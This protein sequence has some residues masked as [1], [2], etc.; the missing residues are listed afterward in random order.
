MSWANMFNGGGG[1]GGAGVLEAA[2]TA[3]MEAALWALTGFSDLGDGFYDPFVSG[4][5]V[6]LTN[7]TQSVT[8]GTN[9][10]PTMTSNTSPSGVC[11]ASSTYDASFPAW[12][13]ADKVNSGTDGWGSNAVP[14]EASPQWWQYEF[15]SATR[16]VSFGMQN[17]VNFPNSPA[18]FAIYATNAA[19]PGTNYTASEWVK[20]LDTTTNTN[21]TGGAVLGPWPAIATGDFTKYRKVITARNSTNTNVAIGEVLFYPTASSKITPTTSGGGS[22]NTDVV[23]TMTSNTTGSYVASASNVFSASY[24]A[25]KAYDDSLVGQYAGWVTEGNV[26]NAYVQVDMGSAITI[27][28]YKLSAHPQS[29]I[30]GSIKTWNYLGSTD[31]TSWTT[32]H[33]GSLASAA[34]DGSVIGTYTISSPGSYR[35]YRL[36]ILTSFTTN[37]GIGEIEQFEIATPLTTNEST[38]VSTADTASSAPTYAMGMVWLDADGATVTDATEANN[39]IRLYFSR[40]GGTSWQWLPLEEINTLSGDIKLYACNEAAITSTSGTSV[41]LKVTSHDLG[42]GAPNYELHGWGTVYKVGS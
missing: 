21:N 28:S 32:L 10:I 41:K 16:V 34:A 30:G 33:S 13:A 19:S 42:S 29:G 6:V 31:G 23:P 36:H 15:A 3:A 25:Y 39:A 1:G 35:Y 2:K 9:L 40:D 14:T 11:S 8:Q 37:A 38:I 12:K 26:T 18:T 20:V 22:T 7:A 5:S 4:A 24:A 17:R 27:G